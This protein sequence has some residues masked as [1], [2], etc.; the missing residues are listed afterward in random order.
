MCKLKI[1]FCNFSLFFIKIIIVKCP[2]LLAP[3]FKICVTKLCQ[4]SLPT[5]KDYFPFVPNMF[6]SSFQWVPINNPI[7]YEGITQDGDQKGFNCHQGGKWIKGI[8]WG[9]GGRVKTM[10]RSKTFWSPHGWQL[11]NFQ[12]LQGH[13][14]WI[15]LVTKTTLQLKV[16][17]HHSG[18]ATKL[19]CHST[20]LTKFDRH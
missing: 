12:S 6:H 2:F 17:Y 10:W 7:L 20:T 19:N 16:F 8:K 4:I 18:V 14:D 9:V 5:R 13:S 1:L 15:F 3:K 11:K